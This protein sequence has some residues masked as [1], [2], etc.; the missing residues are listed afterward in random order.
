MTDASLLSTRS[1]NRAL[2]ERQM[3]LRRQELSAEEVIERLV[4]MQAQ[5]PEAPYVGLWSRLDS[6]W[7]EELSGLIS[8]RWLCGLP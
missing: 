7:A 3:L 2:L 4:G 6:F 5:V 8:D 1:L